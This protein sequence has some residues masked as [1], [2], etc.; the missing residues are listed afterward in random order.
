[1]LA[2]SAAWKNRVSDAP[3]SLGMT[4]LAMTGLG[5]CLSSGRSASESGR[6]GGDTAALEISTSGAPVPDLDASEHI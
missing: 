3:A 6:P 5:L 1:M 2:C 4:E